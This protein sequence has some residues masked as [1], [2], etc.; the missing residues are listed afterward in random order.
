MNAGLLE[1][2][3]DGVWG[4]AGNCTGD[5]STLHGDLTGLRDNLSALDGIVHPELRGNVSRLRGDITGLYGTIPHLQNEY[6]FL[7][8]GGD[9]STL[10][11]VDDL[12][13]RD[14]TLDCPVEYWV[15]IFL[16]AY[17]LREGEEEYNPQ[18]FRDCVVF[19]DLER[20]LIEIADEIRDQEGVELP[21]SL[22]TSLT[23]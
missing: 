7:G 13:G 20:K 15:L 9:V 2:D 8:L 17:F 1:G 22:L 12:R 19:H 6:T 14:A 5:V 4:N 18:A 10:D 23:H 3:L 21:E 11:A 16:A